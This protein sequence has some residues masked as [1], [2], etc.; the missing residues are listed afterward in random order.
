MICVT[1]RSVLPGLIFYDMHAVLHRPR[2]GAAERRGAARQGAGERVKQRRAIGRLG[3]YAEEVAAALRRRRETRRP[4]VR[5]RI[6]TAR[7]AVLADDVARKA[8]AAR[9]VCQRLVDE[10]RRSA[11]RG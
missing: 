5:V 10:E 4:R 11:V 1:E 3:G 8:A 9:V 6:G 7:R 2:R